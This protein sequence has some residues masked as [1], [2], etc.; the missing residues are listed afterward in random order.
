MN[1]NREKIKKENPGLSVAEFGK[2]AGE[3]W[4]G[5]GDKSQWESPCR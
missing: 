2:K 1:E 3:L 5:L 4:K